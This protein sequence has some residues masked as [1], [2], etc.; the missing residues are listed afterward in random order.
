MLSEGGD[1]GQ[2]RTSSA[3]LRCHL[4]DELNE[5]M[6][7]PSGSCHYS[8]CVHMFAGDRAFSITSAYVIAPCGSTVHIRSMWACTRGANTIDRIARWGDFDGLLGVPLSPSGEF[9]PP[10]SARFTVP[11]TEILD[12]FHAWFHCWMSS[13]G[14]SQA[15]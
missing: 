6:F 4:A 10:T 2:T 13:A 14:A 15:Q 8:Y 11:V 7:L 1:G 5:K 3:C 9:Q 12:G